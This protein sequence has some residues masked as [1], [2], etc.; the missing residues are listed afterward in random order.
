MKPAE[1]ETPP[2]GSSSLKSSGTASESTVVPPASSSSLEI[3]PFWF[4]GVRSV[5]GRTSKQTHFNC[6][7][8]L[9]L[10]DRNH[11]LNVWNS[12]TIHRLHVALRACWLQAGLQVRRG[13]PAEVHKPLTDPESAPPRCPSAT[14]QRNPVLKGSTKSPQVSEVEESSNA[15]VILFANFRSSVS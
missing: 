7:S 5:T 10:H 11:V 14:A 12:R 15:D 2:T 6:S 9:V 8:V 4:H 1:G 3:L 13:Q